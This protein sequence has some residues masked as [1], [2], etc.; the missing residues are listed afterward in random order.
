MLSPDRQLGRRTMAMRRAYARLDSILP[1]GATLQFNPK[2]A[3]T[4]Y[5]G[6][7]YANRQ[8]VA[9]DDGCGAVFSGPSRSCEGLLARIAPVFAA[10]AM[11]RPSDLDHI[12]VLVF[13]DT[14]PA[15]KDKR[16]WIWQVPPLVADDYFRAVPT[17]GISLFGAHQK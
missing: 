11:P 17:Q 1:E 14:D 5:F 7:V 4:G 6:G 9:F 16:S 10:P 3:Y 12:D 2:E 13:Q 8:F 15:C